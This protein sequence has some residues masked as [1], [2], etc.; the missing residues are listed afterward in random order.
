MNSRQ[1]E[2]GA[3]DQCLGGR[4]P[5]DEARK[6]LGWRGCCARPVGFFCPSHGLHC[7]GLAEQAGHKDQEFC[8]R[9]IKDEIP[10]RQ[11]DGG[12][13]CTFECSGARASLWRECWLTSMHIT[14]A[15]KTI[16]MTTTGVLLFTFITVMLLY[17]DTYIVF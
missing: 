6:S 13:A 14:P 15:K 3:L 7:D 17:T 16:M 5:A 2:A 10:G 1:R 8:C 4:G 11:L 12:V 9:G